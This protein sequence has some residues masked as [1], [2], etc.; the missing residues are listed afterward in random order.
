MTIDELAQASTIIFENPL[1]LEDM[2]SLLDYMARELPASINTSTK[3]YEQRSDY[4][5]SMKTERGSSEVG[6][7]ITN[8]SN[9][10]FDSFRTYT[11]PENEIGEISG[12]RFQTIPGYELEEHSEISRRLWADVGT[13]VT[14]YFQS[15][16]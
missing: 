15:Q 4:G 5:E 12:M 3:Y 9:G 11:L 16:K 6:G 8:I 10:D 14:N 7:I 2:E 13:Q 1:S